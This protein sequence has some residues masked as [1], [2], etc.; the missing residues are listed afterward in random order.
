LIFLKLGGSAITDKTREAAARLDV[1]QR[2]AREVKNA[3]DK[4]PAQKILVGHGSGSF[5]H[6]AAKKSGYGAQGD[7]RAYAETGAAAW[8]LTRIVTDIFLDAGVPM[9]AMQPSASAMCRDGKL[10]RL[11]SEPAQTALAHN[12]VPLVFGDVSFDETRRMTIVSTEMIFAYLAPILKPARI[13]LA[14]IVDG[15]FTGDPLKNPDA[16]LIREIT[17][18]NFSRIEANLSG[19]H[20]VDTTGGMLTKVKGMLALIE[21]EPGI[22]ARVISAMRAG[23]IECALSAE[24]FDEGTLLTAEPRE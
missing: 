15:V 7:W 14:G 9:V 10:I 17:P 5:G 20:G 16:Q 19:S 2:I 11:A 21:R 18:A 6:Y 22:T 4:N 1:I 13:V 24:N 3:Y 8:R 23:M 12:L